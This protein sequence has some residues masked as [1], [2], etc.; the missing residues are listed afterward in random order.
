MSTGLI[1]ADA[2]Y[3]L[4]ELQN[5]LQL[6]R[7]GDK[8]ISRRTMKIWLKEIDCPV[9]KVGRTPMVSGRLLLQA[10]EATAAQQFNEGDEEEV[11]LPSRDD[12]VGS[13]PQ[14]TTRS[15]RK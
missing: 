7:E 12:D 14:K 1:H 6:D 8:R 13:P 3:T 5:I 4:F 10:I 9:G 2:A 15:K 11:D